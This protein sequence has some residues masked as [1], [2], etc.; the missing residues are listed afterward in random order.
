MKEFQNLYEVRKT[1]RFIAKPTK[2]SK[3][4]ID[5]LKIWNKSDNNE[6]YK[7]LW[8]FLNNFNKIIDWSKKLFFYENSWNLKN[9]FK[10]KY[11][12]LQSHTKYDFYDRKNLNKSNEKIYSFKDIDFIE[13]FLITY[14]ENLDEIHK[15]L[16]LY[17]SAQKEKQ[18]RYREIWFY[19]QKLHGK[20]T[21]ILKDLFEF[22]AKTNKS[23]IDNKIEEIKNLLPNFENKLINI[24]KEFWPNNWIEIAKWCFNYYV[25]NKSSR[26]Y[27]NWEIEKLKKQQ[28]WSLPKYIF[29]FKY[30]DENKKDI[31]VN[32]DEIFFKNIWLSKKEI[33]EMNLKEAYDFIKD[34]KAKRKSAFN[35]FVWNLYTYE[36]LLENKKSK[37]KY[38]EN[39]KLKEEE[40]SVEL[41]CD[42]WEENFTEFKRLTNKI[43][44]KW[45]K[46]NDILQWLWWLK[47][48]E[49]EKIIKN[50]EKNWEYLEESENNFKIL[51]L[52]IEDLAKER[53]KFFNIPNEKI[54]T[55]NY[56]ELCEF[57]KNIALRLWQNKARILWYEKQIVD[58]EKLIFFATIIERWDNKFLA[59]I[60]KWKER[61][62]QKAHDFLDKGENNNNDWTIKIHYFKSL[63]LRALQKLCFKE[64]KTVLVWI[65][66]KNTFIRGIEKELSLNP[67]TQ[68]KKYFFKWKLKRFDEFK[69]YNRFLKKEEWEIDKQLLIEFYQDVLQTKSAKKVLDIK[70]FWLDNVLNETFESLDD[71]EIEFE[72]IAYIKKTLK[73]D[74]IW[75]Q[76]FIEDFWVFLY[77]INSQ[78]LSINNIEHKNKKHTDYWL[79]FWDNFKNKNYDIKINPEFSLYYTLADKDLKEKKEQWLLKEPIKLSW[80]RNRKTKPQLIFTTNFSLN[81]NEKSENLAFLET[82]DLKEN[83]EK[84]NNKLEEDINQRYS[85]NDLW[86]FWIDR[87][88]NELA[89]LSVTKFLNTKNFE[90]AKIKCLK[91]KDEYDKIIDIKTD[92]KWITKYIFEKSDYITYYDKD[93]PHKRSFEISKNISYFLNKSDFFETI[94]TWIIDLTQAKLIWDKIILNWAKSTLLKLKELSAK[95]RIFEK[96]NEI[97]KNLDITSWKWNSWIFIKLNNWK[98]IQVYWFNEDLIITSQEKKE[99]RKYRENLH[100]KIIEIFKTYFKEIEKNNNFEDLETISKIN[101]LRDAITSNMIWIIYFLMTKKNWY[102]W[103]IVL[104]NLDDTIW[105]TWIEKTKTKKWKFDGGKEYTWEEIKMIDGHFYQSNTDISR[106]LEW[107]LYRKFQGIW[108]EWIWLVPPEIKQSVFLKDDFWVYKFWIIEFIKTGW[109]SSTCPYCEIKSKDK[110]WLKQHHEK[111][112]CWFKKQVWEYLEFYN[113]D[114]SINYDSIAAFTVWKFSFEW[115]TPKFE[116]TKKVVEYSKVK[117]EENVVFKRSKN[118]SYNKK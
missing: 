91:L 77:K 25:L 113:K 20:N 53:W 107:S 97:D 67:E 94:T 70:D 102:F 78:D 99:I 3:S 115:K 28:K 76:K 82:S 1:V 59:L 96:Y 89:T 4:I 38:K 80:L 68:N 34:F 29:N 118:L 21:L 64:D 5:F 17:Q 90:F 48:D 10:I 71:F 32:L 98:Y 66:D 46:K 23:W 11:K 56:K 45:S 63:T 79:N 9:F 37:Y 15:N 52:E 110:P 101:H 85:Q 2:N 54:Y 49:L 75:Y 44:E 104:E 93:E 111:D 95:R 74:E 73:I 114:N 31:F 6:K 83:I 87:W 36:N 109:T 13:N 55:K 60:P 69:I 30:K 100:L 65:E 50:K 33:E 47:K 35:Q 27:F 22:L 106:R 57:Y 108:Y 26:E 112:N 58:S 8:E 16:K 81:S 86:Y 103:K 61:L 12:F 116:K 51:S 42:I 92:E 62:H 14:F 117:R 24:L 84:F 43:K 72:K 41:F 88:I 40:M 39:W 105:F 18:S 19:L 7:L